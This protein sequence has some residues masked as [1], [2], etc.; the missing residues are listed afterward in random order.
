MVST[1]ALDTSKIRIETTETT[2]TVT[3]SV[4]NWKETAIVISGARSAPFDFGNFLKI[5]I[6]VSVCL[7]AVMVIANRWIR[8]DRTN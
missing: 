8:A 3:S 2:V 7:M 6:Y 5:A 4:D 1:G